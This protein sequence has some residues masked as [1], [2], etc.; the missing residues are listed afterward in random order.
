MWDKI[1]L[2]ILVSDSSHVVPAMPKMGH[3]GNSQEPSIAVVCALQFST[4]KFLICFASN[5][6]A[7][8]LTLM[9]DRM[10]LSLPSIFAPR[11]GAD[12]R[13]EKSVLCTPGW[14]TTT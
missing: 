13:A 11:R 8:S 12:L 9:W 6:P 4:K 1:Q 3:H 10:D 14:V 5:R 7:T 2:K